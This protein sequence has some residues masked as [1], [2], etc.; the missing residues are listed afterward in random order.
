MAKE[1]LQE[2]V[3]ELPTMS[4]KLQRMALLEWDEDT[5]VVKREARQKAPIAAGNLVRS[6]GKLK[7]RFEKD[8][9]VSYVFAKVPY[10]YMLETGIAPSG[11]K[12]HLKDVGEKSYHKGA[13]LGY[14]LK[15]KKGEIGYMSNAVKEHSDLFVEGI[16]RIISKWWT[17]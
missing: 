17:K 16:S 12:I 5:L 8:G 14:Q 13:G 4:D 7:A 3:K 11:K 1:T 10:A 6:I 15:H 9:I 2:F